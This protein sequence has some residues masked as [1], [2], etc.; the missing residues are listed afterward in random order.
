L[1]DA[2]VD[3]IKAFKL[4]V[5]NHLTHEA[6]NDI[7]FIYCNK[8][9]IDSEWKTINRMATLA[10]IEPVWYDCCINT[11][12]AFTGTH[13]NLDSCIYCN[14][15]RRDAHENPRRWFGY[16]PLIP[17]LRGFFQSEC[18][19]KLM[20]YWH[21]YAASDTPISDVF[22]CAVY[23]RLLGRQVVADGEKLPHTYFCGEHDIAFS[24]YSDG[25][26]VSRN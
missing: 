1:G 22:D 3:A 15:A 6:Y 12:M 4:K 2:D 21:N 23:H 13:T 10:E 14:E 20:S 8:L 26:L 24:F 19:V 5:K 7:R 18:M 17:R 25:Y 9:D 11:C 16:L